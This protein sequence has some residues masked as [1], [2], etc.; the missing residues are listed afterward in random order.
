MC[1]VI[2]TKKLKVGLYLREFLITLLEMIDTFVYC[3]S[4]GKSVSI[5]QC[6]QVIHQ[7]QRA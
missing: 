5:D 1:K 3:Q 6:G 4:C 2:R 7:Y